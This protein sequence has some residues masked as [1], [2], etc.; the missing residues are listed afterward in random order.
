MRRIRRRGIGM[1][2]AAVVTALA[3]CGGSDEGTA[4]G[5]G[6]G[7][8]GNGE[9][10][11]IGV[12]VGLSGPA[13]VLGEAY[14]NA[15]KLRVQQIN[16]DG[17]ILGRQVELLVRDNRS[18][19][20][21]ALTITRELERDGAA[22]MLGPGTSPTTLAAME[23]ILQA[24][25]PTISMGSAG[26]IVQPPQEKR[27]VFKT[28][29]DG[30][31][32]AEAIV[33]DMS[34]RDIQAAALLSVNNPYGDDGLQA[35][36]SATKEGGVELVATEKFEESDADVTPQLRKL[37]AA[38]PDALV[39]W[40]IP[41]GAPNVRRN[42]LERLN[43]DIPMYF[44]T[45]A[46]AELFLELAG[47]SADGALVAQPPSLVWDQVPESTPLHDE[48]QRFGEA[49]TKAYG[50]MSGFAGY[51]WDAVGLLKAAMEKAQSAESDKLNKALE[52]LG[53][54]RGVSGTLEYSNQKHSGMGADDLVILEV[55]NGEW[56]LP[57]E[58]KQGIGK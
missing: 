2:I 7:G 20:T 33:D 27:N 25:F 52:Q 6:E 57:D 35:M 19:Q 40:A 47:T 1:A 56:K 29:P 13:S 14:A 34:R 31:V 8:G 42:A 30:D 3:G 28:P 51:S 38:D 45:G 41:P 49:Y 44:D 18:D 9:P 10:I 54:Y 23:A 43:V 4:G 15:A 53:A 16:K 5:G 39:V 50:A 12:N 11:K 22:A 58:A 21:E 55:E 48:M 17:G 24:G 32:V 37:L 36:Q 26:A 46:G